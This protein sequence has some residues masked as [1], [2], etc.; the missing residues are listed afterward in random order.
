MSG[1][2]SQFHAM[3]DEIVGLFAE[4]FGD[5]AIPIAALRFPPM[6]ASWWDC[7]QRVEGIAQVL[8]LSKNIDL[9]ATKANDIL[10]ED[11]HALVLNISHVRDGML[12]QCSISTMAPKG[13]VLDRWRKGLALFKKRTFTGATARSALSGAEAFDKNM[14]FTE[15][16]RAAQHEGIKMLCIGGSSEYRFPEPE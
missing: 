4:L 8:F 14:R 13:E 9:Q 5:P 16:A 7:S 2:Q 3:A 12:R 1:F 6:S 10:K 15:G 11:P